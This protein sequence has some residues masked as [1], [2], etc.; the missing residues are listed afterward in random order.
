[1]KKYFRLAALALVVILLLSSLSGCAGKSAYDIAVENGFVGSESEWLDSLKGK[2]GA[3]GKDGEKGDKGDVGEKGD[4][5]ERGLTGWEGED[6]TNVVSSYVDDRSHL[7]I[8]LSDGSTIDAGYIGL[9][10]ADKGKEPS[11]SEGNICLAP[12][13]FYIL[14]SNLDYPLWSSSDT[15]VVRVAANGLILGMNEGVATVTATSVDGKTASC[16]ITVLDLEY[17]VNSEGGAVINAYN[18]GLTE[19]FIPS[20][21]SGNPVVEIGAWAFFDNSSVQKIVLP[22]SVKSIGYGAF[23]TCYALTEIDLG[24]GLEVIGTSAFSDCVNLENIT[25]PESLTELGNAAF[26]GCSMLAEIAIPSLVTT[27]NNGTFNSC[28]RLSKINMTNVTRIGDFAFFDCLA[29]ES[30]TLPASLNIIGESAFGNCEKLASVTFENPGTVYGKTSF[31]GCVFAPS[32]PVDGFVITDVVMYTVSNATARIAP[33]IDATA[34]KWPAKGSEIKVIGI[35]VEE[36]WAR[37]NLN[38]SALYI[39]LNL[40]S[41]E[42]VE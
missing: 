14:A 35:Y 41:F 20:F 34:Q 10:K 5:G 29:L 27:I 9:D 33:S 25:L 26:Y 15:N 12:G 39:K 4:A 2:D 28:H 38:G 3:D 19:V 22:D 7:I 18:G 13:D 42:P 6:G 21:I 32:I 16:E 24:E 37:V 31:E 30:V 23:S 11:L 36:G 8:E 40:L 1:M 17:S